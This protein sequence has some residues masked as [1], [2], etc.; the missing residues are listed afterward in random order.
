MK[1]IKLVLSASAFVAPVVS[2]LS[3]T[4]TIV[5]AEENDV[6]VTGNLFLDFVNSTTTPEGITYRKGV[7][8][9]DE[10]NYTDETEGQSINV[11][12][13]KLDSVDEGDVFVIKSYNSGEGKAFKVVEATKGEEGHV[14]V[15]Y[16]VP[17]LTEV[18]K[19]I[20]VTTTSKSKMIT[21]IKASKTTM[22]SAVKKMTDAGFSTRFTGM[23]QESYTSVY[24]TIFEGVDEVD[25]ADVD[26]EDAYIKKVN[27]RLIEAGYT[28]SVKN[29]I[30]TIEKM[31]SDDMSTSISKL[32]A[33]EMKSVNAVLDAFVDTYSNASASDSTKQEA[34]ETLISGLETV[35]DELNKAHK[36]DVQTSG[37]SA[38]TKTD[39]TTNSET[40]ASGGSTTT[41]TSTQDV[42]T[43]DFSG[44][45][46]ISEMPASFD[47]S[48]LKV[49]SVQGE[50]GV[51]NHE[52]NYYRVVVGA[53]GKT[54]EMMALAN[55]D[56]VEVLKGY[57]DGAKIKVSYTVS[58]CTDGAY[59][60]VITKMEKV[61]TTTGA[62]A[63]D[64]TTT[65]TGTNAD[66][67]V[68]NNGIYYAVGLGVAAVG[69]GAVVYKKKK[70]VK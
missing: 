29:I 67:N 42:K 49:H 60:Y 18:V 30:S 40:N 7:I 45:F 54:T 22:E 39:T 44:E 33:D 3:T 43:G 69:L 24:A 2:V 50:T 66:T 17:E 61:D 32:S 12:T 58:K 36:N 34:F 27:Q 56:N 11:E 59:D 38:E 53:D 19:S 10:V 51:D 28:T 70:E 48:T 55:N 8:V 5:S 57:T 6:T 23:M 14:V 4:Q 35:Q 15:K 25:E 20:N 46:V 31:A 9:L 65:V 64:E 37:S 68:Q 62:T 13:D 41:D 47:E 1:G 63:T 52:Y 26:A 21:R 16:T